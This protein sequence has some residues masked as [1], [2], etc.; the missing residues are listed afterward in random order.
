MNHIRLL[1][2]VFCSFFFLGVNS[3]F[4]DR[5]E[6]AIV[7]SLETKHHEFLDG[8]QLSVGLRIA[9]RGNTPFIVDTY[10]KF[11]ENSVKIYI[12][13]YVGQLLFPKQ[14]FEEFKKIMIMPGAQQD[15]IVNL[16]DVFG[17]IPQGKY[18]VHA[19]LINGDAKTS[20]NIV[21]L[22]IVKGIELLRLKNLREGLIS[23]EFLLYTLMYWVRD[24]GE[25]LFLR[26]DNLRTGQLYDFISLGNLVRV[27]KP[28]I[29]FLPQNVVEVLHQNSRD[30][31][32]KTRISVGGDKSVLLSRDRVVNP[33]A[34]KEAE[35]LRR[36]KEA[37]QREEEKNGGGFLRRHK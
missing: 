17:Q 36:T 33:S 8:E 30:N 25:Q 31:F 6:E 19:I 26:I 15:F 23:N 9:N 1:L 29:R 20:S 32:M 37:L 27:A 22:E 3:L 24:G 11:K 12:R 13:N 21:N 10:G 5:I 7:L 28:S 18:T 35:T 4:A 14:E 16:D 34:I 2:L